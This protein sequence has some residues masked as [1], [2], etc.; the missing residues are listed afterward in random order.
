[1]ARRAG[2]A[3]RC[4]ALLWLLGVALVGCLPIGRVSGDGLGYAWRI[5]AGTLTWNP[6]HLLLDPAGLLW[7]RLLI[8]LGSTRPIVDQLKLLSVA[9]AGLSPAHIQW[10]RETRPAL[11]PRAATHPPPQLGPSSASTP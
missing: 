1:M 9:A 7:H 6:N 11:P 4:D 2:P 8:E 3:D 5:A 10:G